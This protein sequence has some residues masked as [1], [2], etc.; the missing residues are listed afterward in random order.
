MPSTLPV[1]VVVPT[2]SSREQFLNERCLPSIREN[3]DVELIVVPGEGNGNVKRNIGLA[4]AT[5]PYVLFVDDDNILRPGCIAKMLD[6]IREVGTSFVYSDYER[7]IVPGIQSIAP[8]GRFSAGPFSL[9]RLKRANFIN[10]ASMVRKDVCPQWDEKLL[11]FQ[12]WDFWLTI[13]L[14]GGV[15]KYIPEVLYELWQIDVSVTDAVPA[16][17]SAQIISLKHKLN[18]R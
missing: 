1:S 13:T 18:R 14:A 6:A 5:N 7:L 15:G 8:S 17:P 3:G 4:K 9:K 12:D 16:N 10:T 2:I 11:R